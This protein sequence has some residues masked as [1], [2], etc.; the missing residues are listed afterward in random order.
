MKTLAI[1]VGAMSERWGV[2]RALATNALTDAMTME[3]FTITERW[4]AP[5]A[6]IAA[7]PSAWLAARFSIGVWL[8][9]STG[10]SLACSG[11]SN[12]SAT[13]RE[14]GRWP[15]MKFALLAM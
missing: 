5:A 8:A 12:A 11:V 2:Q 10:L 4:A 9:G 15:W 14:T 3:R 1:L 13:L 7:A 6:G